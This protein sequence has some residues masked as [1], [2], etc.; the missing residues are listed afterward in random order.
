MPVVLSMPS[1]LYRTLACWILYKRHRYIYITAA[2]SFPT[3]TSKS[4]PAYT[5][6]GLQPVVSSD[7]Q[8]SLISLI[9][10]AVVLRRSTHLAA[11]CRTRDGDDCA[12]LDASVYR[13]CGLRSTMCVLHDVTAVAWPSIMLAS[14][15]YNAGSE[16]LCWDRWTSSDCGRRWT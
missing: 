8:L 5:P 1:N 16:V 7:T 9:N 10:K 2:K 11:V 15:R 13:P 6:A 3:K 12:R 14:S 4:I